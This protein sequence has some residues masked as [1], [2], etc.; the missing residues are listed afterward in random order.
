M[1]EGH[2][3]P[4]NVPFYGGDAR[5]GDDCQASFLASSGFM[6]VAWILSSA[7][8]INFTASVQRV[9]SVRKVGREP[10]PERIISA[11]VFPSFPSPP[12]TVPESDFSS[13]LCSKDALTASMSV[14]DP[15]VMVRYLSIVDCGIPRSWSMEV[16]F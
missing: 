10:I 14:M 15:G 16:S 4:G 1:V 12:L 13:G 7:L 9:I 11:G 3:K 8:R 5:G 6:V 2:E